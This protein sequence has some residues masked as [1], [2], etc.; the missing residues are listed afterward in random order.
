MTVYRGDWRINL[1]NK[2]EQTLTNLNKSE[3]T[4]TNLNK[5]EQALTNLV[6]PKKIFSRSLAFIASI[7]KDTNNNIVKKSLRRKLAFNI[8]NFF[9]SRFLLRRS[10]KRTFCCLVVCVW[11]LGGYVGPGSHS[12]KPKKALKNWQTF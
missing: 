8:P 7:E 2:S 9:F 3:Q 1:T 6:N 12:H 5:S 11:L 10:Q 4:L